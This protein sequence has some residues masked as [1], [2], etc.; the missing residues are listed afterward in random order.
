MTK[1]HA[2]EASENGARNAA[3]EDQKFNHVRFSSKYVYRDRYRC[4][5][6]YIALQGNE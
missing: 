5:D 2:E 6:R 3:I 4:V 1:G